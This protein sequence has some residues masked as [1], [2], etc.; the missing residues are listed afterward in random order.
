MIA[1]YENKHKKLLEKCKK[2]LLFSVSGESYVIHS[3]IEN[4]SFKLYLP[5]NKVTFKS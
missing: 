2:N 3:E 5:F 1:L 4:M